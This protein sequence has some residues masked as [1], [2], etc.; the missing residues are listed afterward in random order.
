MSEAELITSIVVD[1]PWAAG[2]TDIGQTRADNEDALLCDPTLRLFV[3]ADG[4]GGHA[5]GEQASAAVIRT[6]RAELCA[7]HLRPALDDG[8]DAVCALIQQA[9]NT[10]NA[11]I[12]RIEED[13]PEWKGLGTTVV[14][15]VLHGSRAYVAN[16]GDSRAYL[17]HGMSGRVLTQDHTVVAMLAETQGLTPRE[18]R[19]HPLRNKLTMIVGAREELE[20]AFAICDLQR[21]DR[22]VLCTDGLWEVLEDDEIAQIVYFSATPREAVYSLIASADTEGGE[23]NITAIVIFQ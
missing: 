13:H 17:V 18:V 23:D 3:V 14:L 5:A 19:E 16:I 10:A 8:D 12:L 22:L 4:M 6:L 15:A 9:L 21:G 2:G 1:C 7:E 20:P 11:T